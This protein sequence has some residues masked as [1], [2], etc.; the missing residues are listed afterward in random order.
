MSPFSRLVSSLSV[1]SLERFVSRLSK[2]IDRIACRQSSSER[3]ENDHREEMSIAEIRR[4]K[5]FIQTMFDLKR[6]FLSVNPVESL[7]EIS[8]VGY[9]VTPSVKINAA[10]SNSFSRKICARR[11]RRSMKTLFSSLLKEVHSRHETSGNTST[12]RAHRLDSTIET[13]GKARCSCR[14]FRSTDFTRRRNGMRKNNGPTL[15]TVNCRTTRPLKAAMSSSVFSSKGH[16]EDS[17]GLL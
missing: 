14:S 13:I 5:V 12:L 9:N 10:I 2:S 11:K 17:A 4:S 8:F 3:I 15:F 16:H 1:L 6:A 7:G